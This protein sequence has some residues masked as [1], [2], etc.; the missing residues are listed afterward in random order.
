MG[1]DT[2][3]RKV[4]PGISI[5]MGSMQEVPL[6]STTSNGIV[7]GKRK[8]RASMTNGKSYKDTSSSEDDDDVPLVS[9]P[10]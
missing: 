2:T 7:N 4:D 10:Y 5:R 1:N 9:I 6:G 3:N 8:A